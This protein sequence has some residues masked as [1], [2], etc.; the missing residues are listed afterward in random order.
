MM[1]ISV[2]V[3]KIPL[4]TENLNLPAEYCILGGISTEFLATIAECS[5]LRCIVC[6]CFISD[7]F[8][9]EITL[10]GI[11][12]YYVDVDKEE[13]K[14]DTLLD[15]YDNVRITQAIIFCNS[16]KKVR[17]SGAAKN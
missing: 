11:K 12:Q 1:C 2:A 3:R 10:E 17:V 14:F 6:C 13:W 15:I 7:C 8:R 4:L 16:R 5:G 9:E